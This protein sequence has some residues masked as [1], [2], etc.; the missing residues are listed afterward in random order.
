MKIGPWA[1]LGGVIRVAQ[2]GWVFRLRIN[3]QTVLF[4]Q[5]STQINQLATF[6]AKWKKWPF[7]G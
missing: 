5:P 2:I 4:S 7:L 6:A 1:G 3:R